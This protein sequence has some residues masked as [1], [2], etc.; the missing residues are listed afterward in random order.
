MSKNELTHR[1]FLKRVRVRCDEAGSLRK[2]AQ[3]LGLSP[4]FVSMVARG[5]K[6]PNPKIL[7]DLGMTMSK[8]K[9]IKTTL[10]FQEN[11]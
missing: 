8:T 10:T 3:S 6:T 4:S 11:T 1:Q 7:D 2:Y 9:V 5:E